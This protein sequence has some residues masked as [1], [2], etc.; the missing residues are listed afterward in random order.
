MAA[1]LLLFLPSWYALP[2]YLWI[3]Y[4]VFLFGKGRQSKADCQPYRPISKRVFIVSSDRFRMIVAYR[5]ASGFLVSRDVHV[6]G[7]E[8]DLS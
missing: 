7:T 2:G 1:G 6:A 8:K 4:C 3:C 5:P